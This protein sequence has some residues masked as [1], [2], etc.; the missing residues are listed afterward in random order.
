MELLREQIRQ[1]GGEVG[2][3]RIQLPGRGGGEDV[4]FFESDARTGAG[5]VGGRAIIRGSTTRIDTLHTPN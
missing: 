2:E 4:I 5:R 1:R 3:M